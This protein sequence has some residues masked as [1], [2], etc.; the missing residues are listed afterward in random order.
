MTLGENFGAVQA[1]RR[2][3][4]IHMSND[5]INQRNENTYKTLFERSTAPITGS[6]TQH[7]RAGLY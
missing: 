3:N 7:S 5:E 6:V 1:K 4:G 2:Y